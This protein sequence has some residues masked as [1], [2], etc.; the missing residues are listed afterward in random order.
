MLPR[1]H[2]LTTGA[3]F[4]SASRNG[5]RAGSRT[6]VVHL[7]VD[8]ATDAPVRVGFVVSKA[9]GNAVIRNRVK[10]RLRHLVR[11]QLSSLP[12]FGV[13]VVRALPAS[14]EASYAD[15]AD[16]LARTLGRVSA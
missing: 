6:L 2:R 13:L 8:D 9:V 4:R 7:W 15:L 5:R 14:A 11:E 3:D 12:D 16:D 1:E 10:R